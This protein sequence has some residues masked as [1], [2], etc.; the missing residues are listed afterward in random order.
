ME[1]SR[2]VRITD[3]QMTNPS[4]HELELLAMIKRVADSRK[5]VSRHA[6][7][8][9]D[10]QIHGDAAIELL[11]GLTRRWNVSFEGFDFPAYFPKETEYGALSFCAAK[12]GFR[13]KKRRQLSVAHLLEVI[14]RGAWFE[15][16]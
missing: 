6:A 9:H 5:P 14:H 12:L 7:I 2:L 8:F 4:D 3:Q 13:D 11:D 1:Q 16:V 10:L 15:P